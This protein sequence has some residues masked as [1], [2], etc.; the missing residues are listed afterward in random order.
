MRH[1]NLERQRAE[2]RLRESEERY[3]LAVR[4]ANDGLWECNLKNRE[5]IFSPRWKSML[6]YGDSEIAGDFEEWRKRIHP[7]DQVQSMNKL[8]EHLEG[9][10]ASFE[11][12][13]RLLAK[14]GKWIWVLT[15]AAA[16]RHANGKPYRLVGL[17]T[18]ISRIKRTGEILIHVAE[19]TSVSVREDFFRSLVRHFAAALQ[20]RY[21]FITE[22]AD[23][24]TTRV[25]TLAFW[26]G[27][28]FADNVEYDLAG[29]PCEHVIHEGRI[30]YC[31]RHVAVDYPAEKALGA[32]SYLGIPI[33]DVAGRVIGHLAFLHDE[34][35]TDDVLVPAVFKI[36]TA[37]AAT[38]LQRKW[39]EDALYSEKERAQVTLTSIGDAVMTANV[40]GQVD[41]LNPVAEQLTGFTL[42]EA[43][44]RPIQEVFRLM[45]EYAGE[46]AQEWIALCQK[47]KPFRPADDQLLL[48]RDG[49]KIPVKYSAA[50]IHDRAGSPAGL[51]LVFRDVS[52]ERELTR[53]L[54]WQANHDALTGI[55]NRLE[56]EKRLTQLLAEAK[57][58]RAQHALLYLDVDQFKVVN[59][60]CGHMAGDE[61]LR[62]LSALLN[63]R[64]RP[65]DTLARLGGDEFGILLG[66][67]DAE[68]ALLLA[69]G[70]LQ[71]LNGM[72]FAWEDKLFE[73][74]ASIGLV[75]I[76]AE[77]QGVMHLLT[78][79]DEAC[80]AAKG[81]GR[82]RVHVFQESD[83]ELAWR[84]S[85]MQWVARINEA[86]R[87]NRFRLY[88]QPI[89]PT[90]KNGDTGHYEVLLRLQNADGSIVPPQHFILAAEQYDLMPAVD[91]WVIRALFASQGSSLNAAATP[92]HPCSC[93]YTINLSGASLNDETFPDFI[94]EQ[95]AEHHVRSDN[96]CF[97]ITETAAIA[98][99]ARA[100][101]FMREFAALGCHFY[102]DDFGSG[103]S[104]F[105]YLKNLPVHY[106]KIDGAFIKN[107]AHDPVDFAMVEAI[108]RVGHVMGIRT[109]AEFVENQETFQKLQSVGVDFAQGYC[110]GKPEPIAVAMGA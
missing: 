14:D 70:L 46:P 73:I 20:V 97:E 42:A 76:T 89:M 17:D 83:R 50:P 8:Q 67:C 39:A 3:A 51:V 22:C 29:T 41:F 100:S 90:R 49:A 62:Q 72:R 63:D 110:I 40:N 77:S 19:G 68:K 13:H 57:R 47:G 71:A 24:P 21:A 102:L 109:V 75:P 60:T 64:M 52:R 15:R 35:M 108:N 93:L 80:Y 38:E 66:D 79:A 2:E 9:R 33:Q 92:G 6:G 107:M 58:D 31:P 96:V 18:D 43:R 106:L 84:R 32:E 36:F 27:N 59:D 91:R 69:R 53:K 88:R 44:G 16:I 23:F 101:A 25:R 99:L 65:A 7:D 1:A 86:L 28:E 61:L 30:E 48:C 26:S 78:A 54:A 4:V 5:A 34:A 82:N 104:S 98:N 74:G 11:T 10:T 12:E 56:F 105:A 103:L 55:I 94:R 85:Q 81:K 95:M 37:Q 45:V 87:E